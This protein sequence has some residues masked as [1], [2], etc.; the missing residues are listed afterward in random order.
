MTVLNIGRPI[1]QDP[2]VAYS[3]FAS[4]RKKSQVINNSMEMAGCL[5]GSRHS[6]EVQSA[7]SA[8]PASFAISTVT[9]AKLSAARVTENVLAA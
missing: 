3:T 2:P 9:G 1:E 4:A 6:D 8:P 7:A 5:R